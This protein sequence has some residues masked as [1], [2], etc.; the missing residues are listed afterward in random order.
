MHALPGI[1]SS[2]ECC[3]WMT[4]GL[5]HLRQGGLTASD[6]VLAAEKAGAWSEALALY[7]QA[8]GHEQAADGSS[9]EMGAL[10]QGAAAGRLLNMSLLVRLHACQY[11]S[12]FHL[13]TILV[14]A[15][16]IICSSLAA[17]AA[18]VLSQA[19]AAMTPA[20]L[21]LPSDGLSVLQQGQ[22]RCLL[23]M[24]HVQSLT[25]QVNLA[26]MAQ[27]GGCFVLC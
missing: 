14:E 26:G 15:V 8:L 7:E 25:N 23:H 2:L 16:P 12:A 9:A 24:G 11:G 27:G 1:Y 20:G 19:A 18:T 5:M 21:A 3:A 17:G 22:L 13:L 4:A 10:M 6:Q